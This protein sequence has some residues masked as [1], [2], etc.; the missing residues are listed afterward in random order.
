MT[1]ETRE[2]KFIRIAEKRMSRIFSQMNLI[3]NLSSKKHYSYTDN[4]IDELFQAY[5]N[6]GKEIKLFFESL[7]DINISLTTEFN[8]SSVIEI[9]DQSLT[10]KEKFRNLAESRM[11]KVFQDMSLIANLSNKKNYSYSS[12]Q[13]NEL[14]QA[15]ENKGK[16]I[17]LFF[18]PLNVKFTFSQ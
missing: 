18:E 13:I 7:S 16:E 11:S 9:E 1:K 14:F 10:K 17:K 2:E 12:L 6:K 8:F 5:Q 3:A 15:Y 4:E